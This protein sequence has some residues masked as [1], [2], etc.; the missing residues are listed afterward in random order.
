MVGKVLGHFDQSLGKMSNRGSSSKLVT[1]LLEM[2]LSFFDFDEGATVLEPNDELDAFVNSIESV[3]VFDH[4]LFI[5]ILGFISFSGSLG[6]GIGAL[7]CKARSEAFGKIAWK[8]GAGWQGENTGFV[9]GFI[10]R[11]PPASLRQG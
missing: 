8:V 7:T 9:T 1:E 11:L 5:S 6:N 10:H 4:I 2:S 3:S